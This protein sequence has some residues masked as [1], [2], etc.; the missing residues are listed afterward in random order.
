MRQKVDLNQ[1]QR[2]RKSA[3]GCKKKTVHPVRVSAVSVSVHLAYCTQSGR[4]LCF[5]F[6]LLPPS[7]GKH[8]LRRQR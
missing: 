8:A 3:H 2:L 4:P 6:T 5:Y 1:R 7:V